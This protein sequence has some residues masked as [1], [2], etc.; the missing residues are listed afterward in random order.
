MIA[1]S[2]LLGIDILEA[3][4]LSLMSMF[5][6]A[7]QLRGDQN[8]SIT[9]GGGRCGRKDCVDAG[10]S[11]ALHYKCEPGIIFFSMILAMVVI[12]GL[13]HFWEKKFWVEVDHEWFQ[14]FSEHKKLFGEITELTT[15][16]EVQYSKAIQHRKIKH[17]DTKVRPA[18]KKAI[19]EQTLGPKQM[20]TVIKSLT[21]KAFAEENDAVKADIQAEFEAQTQMDV[22]D[23]DGEGL[24]VM[25]MSKHSGQE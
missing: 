4:M 13:R 3:S 12:V 17:Y 16:Q 20:L 2:P 18:V 21:E 22:R 11:V 25:Q 5:T 14:T 9:C 8:R 23:E 6:T 15:E 19:A 7:A 24:G 10:R 1:L